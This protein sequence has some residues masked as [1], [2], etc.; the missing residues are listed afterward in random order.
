M[1]HERWLEQHG[2]EYRARLWQ[3]LKV[4]LP[5]LKALR[6]EAKARWPKA[7][8]FPS[9]R[10]SFEKYYALQPVIQKISLALQDLLPHRPLRSHFSHII[11]E[12]TGHE[13]DSTD[14]LRRF[15]DADA[16]IEAF[17]LAYA[18]LKMAC[19][20]GQTKEPEPSPTSESWVALL[21]LF[22]LEEL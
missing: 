3:N 21:Y 8:V 12:G 1:L 17:V 4:H 16:I 9:N 18:N 22:H 5:G 15:N 19:S 10:R 11:T 2:E 6:A 14:S 20:A 13:F 7:R